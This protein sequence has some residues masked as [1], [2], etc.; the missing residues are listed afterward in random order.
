MGQQISEDRSG[1]GQEGTQR[2][3]PKY[4]S[5]LLGWGTTTWRPPPVRQHA[6]PFLTYSSITGPKRKTLGIF[7]LDRD[8]WIADAKRGW[9]TGGVE[10]HIPTHCGHTCVHAAGDLLGLWLLHNDLAMTI[11]P[12]SLMEK[13]PY[14]RELMHGEKNTCMHT[15]KHTRLGNF[16]NDT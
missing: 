6:S 7:I 13:K 14:A 4:T 3:R 16:W 8:I 11:T 2:M 10:T 9:W 15:H 5:S 1:L 12:L